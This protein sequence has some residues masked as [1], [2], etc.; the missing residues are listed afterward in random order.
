MKN[1][2]FEPKILGGRVKIPA[3]KSV[4]HRAIIC[5]ALA[6]HSTV[7]G[8]SVSQDITATSEA[9]RALGAELT[10]DGDTLTTGAPIKPGI[11]EDVE[12]S[13]GESASTLRFLIPLAA[14]LGR[15]IRFVGRGRLPQR[16]TMLYKDLLE[17]HGATLDYPTNGEFLPLTVSGRLTGGEYSLRGDISSQFVTGLLFSLA[18]VGEGEVRLTTKL[19]SRPYADLTVDM[20]ARFGVKI[21]ET[22][23]S[24]R[25]IGGEFTPADVTVEGDCSQAAFFGVAAAIGGEITMTNLRRDTKQGDFELF[26]ILERCG[27]HVIWSGGDVTVSRGELRATD[28]DACDIP[29]LVPALAVLASLCDGETKIHGAARLR[30]K[31]SDRIASTSAMIRALGGEVTE[32]EDG[33][34]IRGVKRL[35]GG[36]VEA[37]NDHRI[38]MAAAAASCG[39]ESAVVVD[40]MSCIAKSYPGFVEDWSGLHGQM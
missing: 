38:A 31:E 24:Y 13:C 40:D 36:F 5:A 27:A 23:N 21:A 35:R 28:I 34:K 17:S 6:G 25:V 8:L 30:L 2:K 37:C 33:L 12:V 10:L 29:D 19:E 15:K 11:A 4:S 22:E 3:S 16:T 32:T 20:L 9:L 26:R 7:R 39:S 18:V 14:A 1:M